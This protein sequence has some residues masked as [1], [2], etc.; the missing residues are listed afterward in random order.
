MT[1]YEAAELASRIKL[2]THQA[3]D[4]AHAQDWQAFDRNLE[5]IGELRADLPISEARTIGTVALKDVTEKTG[6]TKV[7][8]GIERDSLAMILHPEGTGTWDGSYCADPCGTQGRRYSLGRVGRHQPG[9]T[10]ARHRPVGRQGNR[11]PDTN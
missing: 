9:R 10:N 5:R 7:T 3:L 11:T 4:A 6:A 1:A 2:A 8:I